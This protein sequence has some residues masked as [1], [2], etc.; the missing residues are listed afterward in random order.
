MRNSKFAFLLFG[1]CTVLSISCAHASQTAAPP[2]LQQ[3]ILGV[4]PQAKCG[5]SVNLKVLSSKAA[6][7]G[8]IEELWQASTCDTHTQIRYLI[9]LAPG[10]SGTLEVIGFERSR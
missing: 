6:S 3:T 4:F 7:N 1:A 9:R 2:E 10:K 5:K 8:E